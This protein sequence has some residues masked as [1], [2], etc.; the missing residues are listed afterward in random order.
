LRRVNEK[1]ADGWK[2]Y[3]A[4]LISERPT[5]NDDGY[6]QT[7]VTYAQAVIEFDDDETG[8]TGVVPETGYD[9]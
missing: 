9:P 6:P 3:G 1:L 2:L 4:T 8:Y 5:P 7:D